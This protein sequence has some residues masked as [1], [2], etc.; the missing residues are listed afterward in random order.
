MYV[1]WGLAW[2]SKRKL[3]FINSE[4]QI[5]IISIEIFSVRTIVSLVDII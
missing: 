5:I 1:Y 3:Y 2:L 4:H